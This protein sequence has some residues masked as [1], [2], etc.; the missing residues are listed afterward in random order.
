MIEK[1]FF[2]VVVADIISVY[3]KRYIYSCLGVLIGSIELFVF[4]LKYVLITTFF[5]CVGFLLFKSQTC[6]IWLNIYISVMIRA[7]HQMIQICCAFD[8]IDVELQKVITDLNIHGRFHAIRL[9]R[10]YFFLSL[11]KEK[12]RK[13]NHRK[14][15]I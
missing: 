8:K 13:K 3:S 1:H 11:L 9:F 15:A 10:W 2:V 12:A 5:V 14:S 6:G 4:L 7:T